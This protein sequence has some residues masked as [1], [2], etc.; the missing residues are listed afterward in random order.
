MKSEG[1]VPRFGGSYPTESLSR[2]H[3]ACGLWAPP[4]E[5]DGQRN[6]RD[7]QEK[8]NQAAQEVECKPDDPCDK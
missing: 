2:P 1:Q 7:D 8:V 3:G 4:R 6:E 5:V